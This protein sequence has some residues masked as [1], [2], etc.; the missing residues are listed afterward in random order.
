[1]ILVDSPAPGSKIVSPLTVSGK[2]RNTW[3][4]EGDFPMVII[5]ANGSVIGQSYC[6]AQDS[7]MTKELVA[8]EGKITFE[9]PA[10]S[11]KAVLL[12]KKDNPTGKP[13][14]DD[15]LEIPVFIR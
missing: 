12:L 4:F 10:S 8:F 5:D 3:F 9:Q 1:M 2:A 15:A 6:S 13:E 11:G 7:W 14:Y